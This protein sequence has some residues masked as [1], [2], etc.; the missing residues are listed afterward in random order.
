MTAGERWCSWCRIGSG[1]RTVARCAAV[2]RGPRTLNCCVDS[3]NIVNVYLT[4]WLQI[5]RQLKMSSPQTNVANVVGSCVEAAARYCNWK[6][7]I[8]KSLVAARCT[9]LDIW[10]DYERAFRGISPCYCVLKRGEY[11]C[12]SCPIDINSAEVIELQVRA[13]AAFR[14][15]MIQWEECAGRRDYVVIFMP[16]PNEFY[17]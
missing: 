4:A 9:N 1:R 8:H 13:A 17:I 11:I 6:Q 2:V 3:R 12:R 15:E 16:C 14:R 10:C 5:G 7:E